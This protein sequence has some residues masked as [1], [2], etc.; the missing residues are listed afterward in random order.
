MYFVYLIKQ[1]TILQKKAKSFL[2][3]IVRLHDLPSSIV[4]NKN[5]KLVSNFWKIVWKLFGTNLKFS[6]AFDPQTDGQAEVVIVVQEIYLDALQKKN[7]IIG[8]CC[9]L[10][11]SLPI[12]TLLIG[13]KSSFQ[14]IHYLA[15]C[16][17]IDV[18]PLSHDFHPFKSTVLCSSYSRPSC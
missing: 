14:I 18:V 13:H 5:V 10:P 11:L 4:S 2:H 1:L 8:T 12:T 17:P 3:E 9:Y 16:Q 15:P 6:S 7:Q